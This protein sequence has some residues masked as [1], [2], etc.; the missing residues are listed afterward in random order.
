MLGWPPRHEVDKDFRENRSAALKLNGRKHSISFHEQLFF[1]KK[2][3]RV[4]R[5][6]LSDELGRVL[7]EAVVASVILLTQNL[8]YGRRRTAWFVLGI[9]G[10]QVAN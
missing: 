2:P 1:S 3:C 9:A 7:N 10:L 8:F 4:L 6:V 5:V